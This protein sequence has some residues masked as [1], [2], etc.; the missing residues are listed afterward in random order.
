MKVDISRNTKPEILSGTV[1]C[2]KDNG[3]DTFFIV[4]LV[5]D[6]KSK[7]SELCVLIGVKRDETVA[8]HDT[9]EAVE[10]LEENY[11][12]SDLTIMRN[13]TLTDKK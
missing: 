9:D 13:L 6:V 11:D 7:F 8:F 5:D 10:W 2:V 4:G 1:L 3:Y 12:C